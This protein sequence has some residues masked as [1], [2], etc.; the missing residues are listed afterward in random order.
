MKF[1][2]EMIHLALMLLK[3]LESIREEILSRSTGRED[4]VAAS[5]QG[6]GGVSKF[7]RTMAQ[8]RMVALVAI[9]A[10]NFVGRSPGVEFFTCGY[11]IIEYKRLNTSIY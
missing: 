11:C 8:E 3:L 7:K 1:L 9:H 5:G 2:I 6:N 10:L 4:R